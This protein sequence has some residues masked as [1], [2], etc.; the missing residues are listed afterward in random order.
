MF[1]HIARADTACNVQFV[2]W[3]ILVIEN[4]SYSLACPPLEPKKLF[5]QRNRTTREGEHGFWMFWLFQSNR[6]MSHRGLCQLCPEGRRTHDAPYQQPPKKKKRD[7]FRCQIPQM[8]WD[9][10]WMTFSKRAIFFFRRDPSRGACSA[11]HMSPP[12]LNVPFWV[13]QQNRCGHIKRL[14]VIKVKKQMYFRCIASVNLNDLAITGRKSFPNGTKSL[15]NAPQKKMQECA[16]LFLMVKTIFLAHAYQNFG[17]K[18]FCTNILSL[19]VLQLQPSYRRRPAACYCWR[20]Y[21]KCFKIRFFFMWKELMKKRK[22]VRAKRLP[23]LQQ[24]AVKL[25][26]ESGL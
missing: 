17:H 20:L 18:R 22:C 19:F 15:K 14:T 21:E 10:L 8:H 5:H 1:T 4:I 11:F 6:L 3:N 7:L 12:D 13:R 26:K 23:Q 25:W 2:K 9:V 16:V 24:M